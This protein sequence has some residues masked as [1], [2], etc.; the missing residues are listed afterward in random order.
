MVPLALGSGQIL[1]LW[2]VFPGRA[3]KP[4]CP[5]HGPQPLEAEGESRQ[6]GALQGSCGWSPA[7]TPGGRSLEVYVPF[8]LLAHPLGL[9]SSSV[10]LFSN[11]QSSFYLPF[12]WTFTVTLTFFH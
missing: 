1:W 10:Q 11:L 7:A 2:E 4:P 3:H 9:G 6:R 8:L 12:N 5:F